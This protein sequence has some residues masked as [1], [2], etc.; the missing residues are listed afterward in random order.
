MAD[1]EQSREDKKLPASEKR[2]REA[3][4]EGQVARSRD[5]GHAVLFGLTGLTMVLF[6]GHLGSRSVELVGRGLRFDRTLSFSSEALADWMGGLGMLALSI[7]L[8]IGVAGIVAAVVAAAVPGGFAWTGKTLGPKWSKISPLAGLKRI[9]SRDHLVD[10]IR[11]SLLVLGLALIAAAYVWWQGGTFAALLAM[12]PEHAVRIAPGLVIQGAGWLLLLLIVIATV[13]V[14]MQWFRHRTNL[15]MTFEQARREHKETE[16]D[17]HVK[18]QRRQRQREM[19]TGRMM[20][21]V[22]EADVV[23]T[24]PTHYAVALKYDEAAAGAPRVVAKGADHVAARIREIAIESGVPML[25]APPLARALYSHVE[26]DAEIPAALYNAVA[27]VLAY[28]YQLRAAA[29][30]RAPAAPTD[31][32]VPAELDPQSGMADEGGR[33]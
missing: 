29:G 32:P 14:P 20:A 24:N 4:E 10:S 31:L 3:R 8:P 5:L 15:K 33:S 7:C 28:V 6:A 16:G 12:A 13:D 25:E 26:V 17:P 30:R 2:L 9:F 18:A 19:S 11:L 22:P 1:Q 23:V 27:Q 21:R